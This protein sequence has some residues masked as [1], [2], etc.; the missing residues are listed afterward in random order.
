MESERERESGESDR[1]QV[2]QKV[3]S[4]GIVFNW[5]GNKTTKCVLVWCVLLY[6][7]LCNIECCIL[8]IGCEFWLTFF[9]CL[10]SHFIKFGFADLQFW[11]PIEK[12]QTHKHI[13]SRIHPNPTKLYDVFEMKWDI[14]STI[15]RCKEHAMFKIQSNVWTFKRIWWKRWERQWQQS[16]SS[17]QEHGAWNIRTKMYGLNTHTHTYTKR[18]TQIHINGIDTVYTRK[19]SEQMK[20][21]NISWS[22]PITA[23][24]ISYPRSEI[25]HIYV[26]MFDAR[27]NAI[28]FQ[29]GIFVWQVLCT[30]AAVAF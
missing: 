7:L 25:T 29:S 15:I 28:V 2:L 21:I 18:C 23:L 1:E 16:I 12:P 27:F 22:A 8:C 20:Y 17:V 10:L 9:L 30:R 14:V 3:E 4:N 11:I 24:F 6:T 13:I 5:I 26:Y 19:I